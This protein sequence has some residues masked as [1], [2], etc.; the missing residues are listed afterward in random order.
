MEGNNEEFNRIKDERLNYPGECH[1]NSF[2]KYYQ[3]EKVRVLAKKLL[4][5]KFSQIIAKLKRIK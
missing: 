4:R 2:T 5:N 3:K 1:I